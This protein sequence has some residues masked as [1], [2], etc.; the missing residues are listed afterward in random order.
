MSQ[1][2]TL[3]TFGGVLYDS[4]DCTVQDDDFEIYCEE[5]A[6][7]SLEEPADVEILTY[8]VGPGESGTDTF[9][10]DKD[11]RAFYRTGDFERC[12]GNSGYDCC[13]VGHWERDSVTAV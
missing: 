1:T 4:L 10:S 9:F 13:L 11:I 8:E 6:A 2:I 5:A 12:I 3:V 7:L